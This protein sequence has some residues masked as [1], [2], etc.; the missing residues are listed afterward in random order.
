MCDIQPNSTTKGVRI[1][2][3]AQTAVQANTSR[4]NNNIKLNFNDDLSFDEFTKLLIQYAETKP[5]PNIN[6]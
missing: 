3:D 4:K 2:V 1:C 6:E 5:Y